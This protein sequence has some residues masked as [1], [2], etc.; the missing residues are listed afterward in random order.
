MSQSRHLEPAE[1]W[2]VILCRLST[3]TT[4]VFHLSTA[5]PHTLCLSVFI[6]V[7]NTKDFTSSDLILI[8][9]AKAGRFESL[10]SRLSFAGA[11]WRQADCIVC[12]PCVSG[13]VTVSDTYVRS[14][15]PR[16]LLFAKEETF[17][18]NF[19]VCVRTI[20]HYPEIEGTAMYFET[21][22][23]FCSSYPREHFNR[24]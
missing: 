13:V 3:N 16:S 7:S 24:E 22:L 11:Q 20:P 21:L 9:G 12:L 18:A 17:R 1:N 6:C 15:Y 23:C 8:C 2:L 4:T 10:R 5:T 14:Q 19:Y